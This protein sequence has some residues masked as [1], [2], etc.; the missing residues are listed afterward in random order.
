MKRFRKTA[1]PGAVAGWL[2]ANAAV[3]AKLDVLPKP[4]KPRT[5]VDRGAV[6]SC[7]K[8][9]AT[10]YRRAKCPSCGMALDGLVLDGGRPTQNDRDHSRLPESDPVWSV[11]CPFC[12]SPPGQKCYH[13]DLRRQLIAQRGPKAAASVDSRPKGVRDVPCP[14][15]RV[16]AGVI[17]KR[18]SGHAVFGGESHADRH[19]DFLQGCGVTVFA[20]GSCDIKCWKCGVSDLY[21]KKSAKCTGCRAPIGVPLSD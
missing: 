15:C 13:A 6:V 17:C 3:I 12:S 1:M 14:T 16:R 5:P 9:R 18:P 20:G 10:F 8:C 2:S 19:G 4:P 11:V 7:P 21:P